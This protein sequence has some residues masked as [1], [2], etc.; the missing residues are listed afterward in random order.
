[1]LLSQVILCP[2]GFAL[3]DNF[4][5]IDFTEVYAWARQRDALCSQKS[6]VGLITR[7]GQ[8]LLFTSY[9]GNLDNQFRCRHQQ[10]GWLGFSAEFHCRYAS[11]VLY[12]SASTFCKL[13]VPPLGNRA[14]RVNPWPWCCKL[15]HRAQASY[16]PKD[17]VPSTRVL[18]CS[19]ICVAYHWFSQGTFDHVL[20]ILMISCLRG[21]W[22]S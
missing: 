20:T 9:Q 11:V 15:F 5:G 21:G 8:M 19:Q 6:H 16:G 14:S 10:K 4:S 3:S 1:M 18:I 17:M 22:M 2:G 7:I 13:P 12:C